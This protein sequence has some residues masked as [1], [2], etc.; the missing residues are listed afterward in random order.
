MKKVRLTCNWCSDEE[1]YTRFNRIYVSDLNIDKDITFTLDEKYDLL[2]V[3]NKP[4]EI[5]QSIEKDK[6]LGVIMEPTWS[7]GING[8]MRDLSKICKYIMYHTAPSSQYIYYPG[9]LPF[10]FDYHEGECLDFYIETAQP[11]T[12]KC[13]IVTSLAVHKPSASSLYHKRVKMVENILK[14]DLDIDIY[15][16]GWDAYAHKDR[17]I[18]GDVINKKD[19][20]IDYEFS[21]AI[22]NCSEG[23][24]FTEKLTDCI[25]LDTTPI[26]Y[27]CPKIDRFFNNVYEL[28]NLD[29]VD[30]I[31]DIIKN[32]QS[33]PQLE[34]KKQMAV[35]YN[36]YV[37][38]CSYIHKIYSK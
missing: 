4:H 26:Y 23:D 1:L 9:L 8:Y 28:S 2:V 13:S 33:L 22:E 11:K 16:K 35:K 10:H 14:T 31:Q 6:T 38:I 7:C 21:I 5:H 25:L 15:G 36:L 29:T 30:E 32:K 37:A 20:L 27:G 34:N 3:I 17:R 18:K 19:A 12:K 24:Y